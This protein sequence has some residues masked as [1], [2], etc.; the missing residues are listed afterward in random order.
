MAGFLIDILAAF[1]E[2]ERELIQEEL[3][4]AYAPPKRQA[5]RQAQTYLSA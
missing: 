5:D 2:V 1:A 3:L 4:Q